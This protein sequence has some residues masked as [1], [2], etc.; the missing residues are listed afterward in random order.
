MGGLR[1]LRWVPLFPPSL[2][3][4][5]STRLPAPL[6]APAMSTS[7][8]LWRCLDPAR[9]LCA[10]VLSSCPSL[11]RFRDAGSRTCRRSVLSCGARSSTIRPPR[12]G[13]APLKH[14][15]DARAHCACASFSKR[16]HCACANDPGVRTASATHAALRLRLRS[17]Q[18]PAVV[19]VSPSR[20]LVPAAGPHAA[21]ILRK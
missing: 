6:A 16:A 14:N 11:W 9:L 12:Y 4:A 18:P 21:N 2:P 20:R 7:V 1:Q 17:H 5:A 8:L 13:C 10:S 19:D 3:V 15:V